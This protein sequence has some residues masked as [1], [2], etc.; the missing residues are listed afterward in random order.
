[1]KNTTNEVSNVL[2]NNNLTNDVTNYTNVKVDLVSAHESVSNFGNDVLQGTGVM[3]V[4]E[5]GV[6]FMR[7][8]SR[9]D[10]VVFY[11]PKDDCEC[12]DKSEY[13]PDYESYENDL[14]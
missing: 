8:G 12:E 9:T 14:D 5:Q 1:M 3:G 4:D 11:K 7:Y 6:Y 13:E 2:V 10:L